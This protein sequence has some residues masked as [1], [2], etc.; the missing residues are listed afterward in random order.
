M[1]GLET[2]AEVANATNVSLIGGTKIETDAEFFDADEAEK[3]AKEIIKENEALLGHLLNFQIRFIFKKELPSDTW[4]RAIIVRGMYAFLT[5]IDAVILL[6]YETWKKLTNQQR[7]GL[8]AHELSHLGVDDNL[9]K[10]QIIR[11]EITEFSWVV[12]RYGLYN[13]GLQVFSEQLDLF[14]KSNKAK[15]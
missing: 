4:G 5:E 11:H 10:L 13:N 1:P 8:I 7:K 12:G 9:E 3:I 2:K 15:K 14:E 6:C